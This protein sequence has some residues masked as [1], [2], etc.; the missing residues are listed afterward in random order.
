[1]IKSAMGHMQIFID[2][3]HV[4]FY[5]ELFKFLEW[6][7]L[8]EDKMSVSVGD[9]NGISLWF[10]PIIKDTKNDY[11][12]IGMNHLA[13]AVFSQRDVDETVL[14][15]R[16]KG[17]PTLFNTPCHRPDFSDGPEYTYYQVMFESPDRILFEV[18]YTG[19][20]ES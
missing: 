4:D 14:W 18:V 10:D 11:D 9:K 16:K 5:K 6:S 7:V 19:I 15:L 3:Q 20:F 8:Y 17:I 13:L 12:G 1:M 2:A